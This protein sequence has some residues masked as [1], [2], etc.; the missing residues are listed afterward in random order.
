MVAQMVGERFDDF[1]IGELEQARALLHQDHARTQNREHA[2]VFHADHAAAHHDEGLRDLR[3]LQNLVAVDDGRAV[4]G[5]GGRNGR[6]GAGGDDDIRRFEIGLAARVFH[7]NVSGVEETGPRVEN[8]HAVAG[9]LRLR[10]VDFRLDHLVDAER[11][12]PP[13]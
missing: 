8:V 4:D 3:H 11:R 7:A 5:Y 13:C 6:L 2:G 10:H 9:Q 1:V 12:G